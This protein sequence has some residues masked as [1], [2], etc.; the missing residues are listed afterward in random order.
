MAAL[1]HCAADLLYLQGDR[2]RVS[3]HARWP[4]IPPAPLQVWFWGATAQHASIRGCVLIM[5]MPH[6]LF[7]V[8]RFEWSSS[9]RF[10]FRITQARHAH[11]SHHGTVLARLAAPI[12]EH[13][14]L[15]AE[16]MSLRRAPNAQ[17]GPHSHDG[18]PT[19]QVNSKCGTAD[20]AQPA[21]N[22]PARVSNPQQTI[23]QGIYTRMC[24]FVRSQTR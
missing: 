16:K 5:A 14:I 11:Y 6:L 7:G 12:D 21:E 13:T 22:D 1:L 15:L 4:C 24:T 9:P 10:R 17:A 8:V 3:R 23:L 19:E 20:H 2:R 18:P